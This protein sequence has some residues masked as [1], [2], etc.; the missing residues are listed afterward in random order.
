MAR[1]PGEGP[2]AAPL[3]AEGRAAEG[4]GGADLTASLERWGQAKARSKALSKHIRRCIHDNVPLPV[5]P[6]ELHRV[7]TYV[8]KCGD[9]LEVHRY[10]RIGQSRLVKADF[11]NLPLLC[12]LCAI[13]RAGR[14]LRR[15]VGR[16]ESALSA[17]PELRAYLIG[18][19][20]KNGDDLAERKRHLKASLLRLRKVRNG[21]FRK[22]VGGVYSIETT[23]RGKG[24]HPH[25][26]AIWL[27]RTPPDK[28]QL[29]REWQEITGDSMIVDVADMTGDLIGGC[30]EVLKYALKNS[31]LSLHNQVLAWSALRGARLVSAFGC[32]Y[33][34]QEEEQLADDPLVEEPYEVLF[35]RFFVGLGYQLSPA[36][37]V[38]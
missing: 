29:S 15:Y 36:A 8:G 11:C 1:R 7:S 13:R 35:Y 30:V 4:E 26:H 23:N 37:A 10:P 38:A 3:L 22:A 25:V 34:V 2:H 12:P 20:V 9:W 5:G 27:C 14:S 6:A 31:D 21:E 28:Y 24:W 16:I 32:L 17:D 19:T 33:G 18:L